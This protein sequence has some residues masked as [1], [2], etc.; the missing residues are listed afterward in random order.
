MKKI[1]KGKYGLI[2]HTGFIG[3]TLKKQ[4]QFDAFYNSSNIETIQDNEFD[5]LVC[6]G[7]QA[8]KWM[9]NKYPEKDRQSIQGLIKSLSKVSCKNFI[10]ISTVDVF[11]DPHGVNE[12][13]EIN[14]DNLHPYGLNRRE[15]E[16]FVEAKF[17]NTL[18]VRLPGLIGP[19]LKKN[20]IYDLH[21]RNNLEIVDSRNIFQFY[22]VINLWDDIQIA[23]R[24]E[25]NVIHLTSE[26]L[27]VR[28]ISKEAFGKDFNN[29]LDNK[30]ISYNFESIFAT[31]MGGEGSYTYSKRESLQSIRFYAQTEPISNN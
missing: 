9:A 17:S 3:T 8:K 6:A 30:V 12:L 11:K 5:L 28:E 31:Q 14:I 4:Y 26:P 27:S 25:T 22:P 20:I 29:P 24:L 21:N 2:G 15:L 1:E 18:I 19:G 23:R 13:S 16:I 10:L 7:A